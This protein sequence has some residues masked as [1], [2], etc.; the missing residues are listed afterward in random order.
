MVN[1]FHGGKDQIVAQIGTFHPLTMSN[2]PFYHA[3]EKPEG[4]EE[5][6]TESRPKYS[7]VEWSQ[8]ENPRGERMAWAPQVEQPP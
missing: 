8:K 3:I 2:T 4:P 7:G 6:P 5:V 1:L